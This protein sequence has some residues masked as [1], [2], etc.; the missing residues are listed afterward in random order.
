MK[1][2]D[3]FFLPF[4]FLLV[5]EQQVIEY[6]AGKRIC[7]S[8][9]IPRIL[10]KDQ[11]LSARFPYTWT[12]STSCRIDCTAGAA[13]RPSAVDDQS[14]SRQATITHASRTRFDAISAARRLDSSLMATTDP[15]VDPTMSIIIRRLAR[16]CTR[17]GCKEASDWLAGISGPG[18]W[19]DHDLIPSLGEQTHSTVI[20]PE[21]ILHFHPYNHF[22]PLHVPSNQILLRFK[23]Q[24][25]V[26]AFSARG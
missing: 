5:H 18:T 2:V 22:N 11:S 16:G 10:H 8:I 24:W 19:M 12:H 23:I 1:G 17:A 6:R 21:V 25:K 4:L 20:T 3:L 26:I 9:G 15:R 13:K 14:A 7:I